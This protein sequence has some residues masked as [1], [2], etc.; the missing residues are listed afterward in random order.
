[1]KLIIPYHS[2]KISEK[3]AE[4]SKIAESAYSQMLSQNNI[5]IQQVR[6][7][8]SKKAKGGGGIRSRLVK[9]YDS[10]LSGNLDRDSKRCSFCELVECFR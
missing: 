5:D 1:L 10:V 6:F 2:L 9:S 8:S 3:S 7:C 4:K